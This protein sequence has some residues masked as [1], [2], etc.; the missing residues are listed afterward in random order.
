[1]K[2]PVPLNDDDLL[3]SAQVRAMLGNIS[4]MTL[5][6][7]QRDLGFPPPDH[8]I[9]RRNYWRRGRA[10]HWLATRPGERRPA[11]PSSLN[12]GAA[13]SEGLGTAA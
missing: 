6:R 9:N 3:T 12:I 11:R 2:P 13:G 4:D 1:M 5:W 10:R 7:W 8:V